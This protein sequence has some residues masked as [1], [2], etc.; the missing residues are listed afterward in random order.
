LFVKN[1]LKSNDIKISDKAFK[2]L[3]FR[4]NGD[5][6]KF[7]SELN[8]FINFNGLIDEDVVKTLVDAN[9]NDNV[10][11]LIY[12]ILS[13]EKEKAMKLLDELF[14]LETSFIY[15]LIIFASNY[16]RLFDVSYLLS[17]NYQQKDIMNFLN[18]TPGA[19]YNSIKNCRKHSIDYFSKCLYDLA[20]LDQKYKSNANINE[21]LELELFILKRI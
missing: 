17:K 21:K 3:C 14:V 6:Y 20:L 2:D 9:L 12:A 16:R 8:K 4:L 15:I 7:I 10:N 11:L 5:Q 18:I 13:K 1:S 19:A